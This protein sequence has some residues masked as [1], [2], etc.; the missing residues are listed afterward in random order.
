MRKG[1]SPL[2]A[3]VILIAATMSI[4]GIL[5]YWAS[6]FV[7]T[8][9]TETEAITG[10][11]ECLGAEFKIKSVSY[12]G[13]TLHLI[14]DNRRSVDL[15]LTNLFLIYPNNEVKTK[16]LNQTLK[17][18]EIKALT[19]NNVPSGFLTGEIKTHCPDVSVFFTYSQA[20]E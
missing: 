7:K 17:G 13:N 3:A 10:G 15:L 8:K 18:N 20:V 19:I 5:A 12:D 9:L 1:L 2:I 16:S 11:T 4:A 6:G 14:L